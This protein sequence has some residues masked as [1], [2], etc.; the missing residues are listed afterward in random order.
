MTDDE[1]VG[2]EQSIGRDNNADDFEFDF[3]T[4]AGDEDPKIY[5]KLKVV[6]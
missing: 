6:V 2:L 1:Y 5:D 3:S 4:R